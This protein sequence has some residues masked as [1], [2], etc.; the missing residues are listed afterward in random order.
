MFDLRGREVPGVDE[1]ASQG[2]AAALAEAL[3]AVV[4][5][6]NL[7]PSLDEFIGVPAESC[8]T[9]SLDGDHPAR[10]LG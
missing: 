4:V 6:G 9:K 8:Q 3:G 7:K 5:L 2:E 1:V 10:L